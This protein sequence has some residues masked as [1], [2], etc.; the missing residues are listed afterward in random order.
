MPVRELRLSGFVG[1]AYWPGSARLAGSEGTIRGMESAVYSALHLH[2]GPHSQGLAHRQAVVLVS[3]L[4][5]WH[6][7]WQA[8]PAQDLH[9]H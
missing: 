6:P 4:E 1:A 5:L 9:A 7:H 2:D 3:V 8:A